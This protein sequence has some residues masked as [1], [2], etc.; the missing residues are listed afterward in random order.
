MRQLFSAAWE[1][2]HQ[3]RAYLFSLGV[4]SRPALQATSQ[5]LD[6]LDG[7]PM[8]PEQA[9]QAMKLTDELSEKVE[10]LPNYPPDWTPKEREGWRLL[11]DALA[12]DDKLQDWDKWV[13]NLP[14]PRLTKS[15]AELRAC[16]GK[17]TAETRTYSF[18]STEWFLPMRAGLADFE[19][20]LTF[21]KLVMIFYWEQASHNEWHELPSHARDNV[22]KLLK[23]VDEKDRQELLKELPMADRRR[24]EA[25][26]QW[27]AEE[28]AQAGVIEP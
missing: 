15:L 18:G 1:T 19:R 16:M 21:Q 23:K 13:G 3:M 12:L 6:A 24:L 28:W 10:K 11:S 5:L 9:W 2:M 17:V 26:K 14:R 4:D 8:E 27:T 25:M 7:E 22:L 20:R